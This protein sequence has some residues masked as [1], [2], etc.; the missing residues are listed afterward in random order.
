MDIDRIRSLPGAP[1]FEIT[2][3]HVHFDPRGANL[4]LGPVQCEVPIHVSF[5]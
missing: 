4:D 1:E 5:F 2:E 3:F